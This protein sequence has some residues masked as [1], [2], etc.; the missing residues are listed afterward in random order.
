LAEQVRSSDEADRFQAVAQV[1]QQVAGALVALQRLQGL[2]DQ[3]GVVEIILDQEDAPAGKGCCRG[4]F[5]SAPPGGNCP[6][7]YA[8]SFPICSRDISPRHSL[9]L[10][11]GREITGTCG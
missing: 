6:K 3:E 10:R 11:E 2:L 1:G 5:H 8:S 9:S 7:Y 4:C